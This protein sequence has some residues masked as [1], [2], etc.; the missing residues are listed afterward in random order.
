[1]VRLINQV[2]AQ[3]GL[4]H[5]RLSSALSRAAASHSRDMLRRDFFDHNSS[6]GT[7]FASRVRRYV[8][9]RAVGEVLAAIGQRHGGAADVDGVAAAPGGTPERQHSADR[10]RAPLGEP[11][12]QRP[13]GDHRGLRIGAL[14]RPGRAP[15]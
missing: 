1:M 7:P 9:A 10:D 2:R 4:G 14:E 15:H 13:G 3:N 11:G 12:R 6:D 5:V 8:N